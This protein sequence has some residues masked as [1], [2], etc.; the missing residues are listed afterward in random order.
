MT[1]LP[2]PCESDRECLNYKRELADLAQRLAEA[3][4]QRD[5]GNQAVAIL[6][7]VHSAVSV[8]DDGAIPNATIAL[9]EKLVKAHAQLKADNAELRTTV[10]NLKQI[11]MSHTCGAH[12]DNN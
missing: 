3:E 11:I 7:S 6:S 1:E 8:V 5:V 9:V 4:R 12:H 10:A 2:K